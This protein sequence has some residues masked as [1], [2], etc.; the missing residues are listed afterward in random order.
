MLSVVWFSMKKMTT[1]AILVGLGIGPPAGRGLV[2][3][4]LA[5]CGCDFFRAITR[6][7]SWFRVKLTV[8]R[9]V[10]LVTGRLSQQE[11]SHVRSIR[12]RHDGC[13]PDDAWIKQSLAA[14]AAISPRTRRR[15]PV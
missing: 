5:A 14:R 6:C 1:F 11:A 15:F 8:G 9:A 4:L 3:A 2:T 10:D 13:G 12:K 7:P